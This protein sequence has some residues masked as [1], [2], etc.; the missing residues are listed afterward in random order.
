[1]K[2]IKDKFDISQE[3]K[4]FKK[5]NFKL[6]FTSPKIKQYIENVI[7]VQETGGNNEGRIVI[8]REKGGKGYISVSFIIG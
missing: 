8:I 5:E 4:V 7:K 6:Y 2:R 3:A 1:M